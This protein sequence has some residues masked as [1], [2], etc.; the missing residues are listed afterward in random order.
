MKYRTVKSNGMSWRVISANEREATHEGRH[1]FACRCGSARTWAIDEHDQS[2]TEHGVAKPIRVWRNGYRTED[3][4]DA[5][6]EIC[7][8][9]PK[10]RTC[11]QCFAVY[12]GDRSECPQCGA[13]HAEIH[14]SRS[15]EEDRALTRAPS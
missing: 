14:P 8:A 10:L 12:A 3:L 5:V 6:R 11:G 15:F 4:S 7:G 9:P 13:A 2:I 1:F